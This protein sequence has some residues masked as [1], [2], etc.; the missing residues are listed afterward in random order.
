M[1][2][3]E[4]D[5]YKQIYKNAIKLCVNAMWFENQRMPSNDFVQQP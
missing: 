2:A 3:L 1:F 5:A 4:V